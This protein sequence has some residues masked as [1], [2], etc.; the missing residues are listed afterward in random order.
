VCARVRKRVR[1]RMR[2][3]AR[4]HCTQLISKRVHVRHTPCVVQARLIR[5]SQSSIRSGKRQAPS[6]AIEALDFLQDA[7]DSI[8]ADT[9]NTY[10]ASTALCPQKQEDTG[11]SKDGGAGGCDG[12]SGEDGRGVGAGWCS[13]NAAAA[14]EASPVAQDNKE[15][16][17]SWEAMLQAL[18]HYKSLHGHT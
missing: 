3:L 17:A 4:L 1:A 12:G 13:G 8:S 11:G 16:P 18:L 5:E 10:S 2:A 15:Q 14:G 7:K 6:T 9:A